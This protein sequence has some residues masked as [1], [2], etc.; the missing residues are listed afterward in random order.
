M[1][2]YVV[3]LLQTVNIFFAVKWQCSLVLSMHVINYKGI[4][5]IT[6]TRSLNL[7]SLSGQPISHAV[8]QEIVKLV[9]E[10]GNQRWLFFYD[11]KNWNVG[12]TTRYYFKTETTLNC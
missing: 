1:Q 3:F 11:P 9:E 4:S 7:I 2:T 6:Q 8:R 12:L 5:S 10:I